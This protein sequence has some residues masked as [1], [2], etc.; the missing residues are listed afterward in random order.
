[1]SWGHL[2][3]NTQQLKRPRQGGS[4]RFFSFFVIILWI[5][6]I[7]SFSV[8]AVS[9]PRLIECKRIRNGPRLSRFIIVGT[10][11]EGG[12]LFSIIN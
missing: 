3:D 5:M 2:Q 7:N 10:M 12:A 9:Q 11:W 4:H 6:C 8:Q 1:M